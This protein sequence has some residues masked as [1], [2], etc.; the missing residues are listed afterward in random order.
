MALKYT[1]T[2]QWPSYQKNAKCQTQ[3]SAW[4]R[5]VSRLSSQKYPEI[6]WMKTHTVTDVETK[7]TNK[8]KN[9][10]HRIIWTWLSVREFTKLKARGSAASS[11]SLQHPP[12]SHHH[13]V[14][15]PSHSLT[16]LPVTEHPPSNTGV[17]CVNCTGL[18]LNKAKKMPYLRDI[19]ILSRVI[20]QQTGARETKTQMLLYKSRCILRTWLQ[21]VNHMILTYIKVAMGH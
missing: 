2:L 14:H 21:E 8:Q 12:T 19:A 9:S 5:F 16:G 20:S 1:D 13:H 18:T 11:N 10:F 4:E 7:K 3:A 15:T 6:A 17:T